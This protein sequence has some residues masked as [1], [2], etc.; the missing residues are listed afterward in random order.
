MGQDEATGAEHLAGDFRIARFIGFPQS[1]AAQ[2]KEEHRHRDHRQR[3]ALHQLAP[4]ARR[5]R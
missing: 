4:P 2:M 1:V 3:R 5:T